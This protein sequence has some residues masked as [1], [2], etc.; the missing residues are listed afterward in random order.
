MGRYR[1]SDEQGAAQHLLVR[2]DGCFMPADIA[3][4]KRV[5]GL[6]SHLYALRHEGDGGIGD[7]ETLRRFA[8][9]TADLGGRYTGLNPLH[10]MFPSD[11]SRVSPY[12]PSD[13]RYLDPIY[14]SIAQLL[15]EYPLPKT[16]KL[17]RNAPRRLCGARKTPRGRLPCALA[18]Q[19]RVARKRL[20]RMATAPSPAMTIS[21]GTAPLKPARAGEKATPNASA[22]VPSSN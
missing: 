20:R 21:S 8:K 4:G 14:I 22:I 15:S 1:V 6:A 19:E 7:F 9:L 16:A 3:G 2:P 10:H 5:F 11:R 12:Q 13:R 18:G 17:A